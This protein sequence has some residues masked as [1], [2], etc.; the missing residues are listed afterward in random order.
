MNKNFTKIFNRL[1]IYSFTIFLFLLTLQLGVAQE[2]DENF[3]NSLPEQ[4]KNDVI[5]NMESSSSKINQTKEYDS[6]SSGVTKDFN[7]E[8]IELLQRFGDEFFKT[9]P[10]TFMPINDPSA[11]LGYIL[12]VDDLLVIQ[13]I[14]DRS[15]EYEYRIDRSGNIS[16]PDIGFVK[17]AGLSLESA[18]KLINRTLKEYFVETEAIISLK[19]VRDINVLITGYVNNPG[20]YVLSGYSSIFHAII[21]AGG[22]AESGSFRNIEVKRSGEVIETFDLY[23][24]FIYGD[25]S[26]NISLRS[27]DAIV[28]LPSNN[29]IPLIGALNRQGLYEFNKDDTFEDLINY[30]GGV[31]NEVNDKKEFSIV[32]INESGANEVV[33]KISSAG[34]I[35]PR[36]NDKLFI[37]YN[38]YKSDALFLSEKEDFID[39]PIIVTGAVKF[40]GEYF[41]NQNDNMLSLINKFGG[42]KDDAYIFGAALF[43]EDAKKLEKEF[44]ARLYNDAI[45]SLASIGSLNRADNIVSITTLLDEFKNIEPQGRVVTEF[46]REELIANPAINYKLTPGDKIHVPYMKKIIY[47]FGEILNPGTLVFDEELDLEDY[48]NKS[49]GFNEYADKTSIII[50]HPN[51]ESERIRFRTFTNNKSNLYPGSVIYVPR[52]LTQIDGIELGSVMAPII[53]SLAI[54]LASLNSI[55]NN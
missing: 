3:L 14:G 22:I 38:D 24:A 48:I 31:T 50:I 13:L 10:S 28:V 40:P 21:S 35:K 46:S 47:T 55:S 17:L 1:G 4:I 41:V 19:E 39:E 16:L 45:K 53:S 44:N 15:E 49:G 34:Q 11:A 7:N 36:G 32:R 23:N 54:S 30:A 37:K 6:F 9:T 43:N 42:F 2:L 29:F 12:D 20:F 51:G 25:T 27:G 5:S 18:S 33:E 52:D 26:S 8:Q